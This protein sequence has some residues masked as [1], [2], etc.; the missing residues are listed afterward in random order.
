MCKGLSER[1]PSHACH[2][3]NEKKNFEKSYLFFLVALVVSISSDQPAVGSPRPISPSMATKKADVVFTDILHALDFL[4]KPIRQKA[5]L[6][7]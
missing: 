3:Q 7:S 2:R 6:G 4:L 5:T 1:S